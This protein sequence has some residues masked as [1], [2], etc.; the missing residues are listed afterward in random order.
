[1]DF[2]ETT[3]K[4]DE[5]HLSVGIWGVLY[6]MFDCTGQGHDYFQFRSLALVNIGCILY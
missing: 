2:V 4:R 3:A 5:K 6:W 1:M